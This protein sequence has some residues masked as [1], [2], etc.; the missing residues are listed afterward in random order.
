MKTI[1]TLALCLIVVSGA[2]AGADIDARLLRFSGEIPPVANLV[3]L[4]ESDL[5]AN[6]TKFSAALNER[7]TFEYRALTP[8]EYPTSFD[9]NG[10]PDATAKRDTG[11]VFSG[12][13]KIS[14][15]SY[16]LNINFSLVERTNTILYP[17]KTGATV[18]QPVFRYKHIKTAITTKAGDWFILRLLDSD[19][20]TA[21]SDPNHFV[22]LV[23]IRR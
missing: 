3:T 14:D 10:K 13:A 2:A 15:G 6:P 19:D 4:L 23:R 9:A 8:N 20:K 17:T 12:D 11:I 16:A 21:P 18:T 5:I 7:N 1:T 22:L